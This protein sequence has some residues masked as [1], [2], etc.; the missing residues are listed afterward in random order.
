ME[1]KDEGLICALIDFASKVK[2]EEMLCFINVD[3]SYEFME[4]FKEK[5]LDFSTSNIVSNNVRLIKFKLS[6][7]TYY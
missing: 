5:I 6:F 2:V 3:G 1:I 7:E 4:L